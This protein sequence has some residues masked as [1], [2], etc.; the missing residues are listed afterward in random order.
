MSAIIPAFN[1]VQSLR[2][3]VRTAAVLG[4]VLFLL[5]LL[6]KLAATEFATFP[7]IGA[8]AVV[9]SLALLLLHVAT[10]GD[11]TFTRSDWLRI[12]VASLLGVMAYR[13]IA[14]YALTVS[15]VNSVS[16]LTLLILLAGIPVFVALLPLLFR[17]RSMAA[18]AVLAAVM[19]SLGVAVTFMGWDSIPAGLNSPVL[20]LGLMAA[21]TLAIYTLVLEPLLKRHSPLK[22][23]ATSTAIG[24]LPFVF[25]SATLIVQQGSVSLLTQGLTLAMA[26]LAWSY[27]TQRFGALPTTVYANLALI[28]SGYLVFA[29]RLAPLNLM[30]GLVLLSLSIFIVHKETGYERSV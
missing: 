7:Y 11:F 17:R 24:S 25:T 1:H 14:R 5:P 19:S 28:I 27:A 29:W 18:L 3:Y 15:L 20:I 26:Y 10:K 2:E 21:L 4:L 30:M 9:G 16:N 8:Q 22:V 23:V 12:G 13:A 6:I